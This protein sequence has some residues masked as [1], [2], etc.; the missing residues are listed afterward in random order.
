MSRLSRGGSAY[1]IWTF[2]LEEMVR[3]YISADISYVAYHESYF[4]SWMENRLKLA[5]H[6]NAETSEKA[7]ISSGEA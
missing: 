5:E 7:V 1:F 2:V 3:M 4:R 6:R